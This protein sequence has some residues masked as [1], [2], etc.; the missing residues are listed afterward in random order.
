MPAFQPGVGCSSCG[1]GRPRYDLRLAREGKSGAAFDLKA[2][3][4]QPLFLNQAGLTRSGLAS[5]DEVPWNWGLVNYA[6]HEGE[7]Y[8]S[9]SNEGVRRGAVLDGVP[10]QGGER[11]RL[12][13]GATI[14][15][16]PVSLS[17]A[18]V[19]VVSPH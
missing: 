2:A 5:G 19:Q 16:G 12:A 9:F 1:Y 8:V 11:R 10:A 7:W 3:S 15:L 6:E 14:R 18:L 13:T 17:V 4:P